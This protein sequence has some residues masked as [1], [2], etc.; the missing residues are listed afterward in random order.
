MERQLSAILAADVVGYSRLMEADAQGTLAK[1]QRLRAERF[2]PAVAGHRGKVVKSMGDGWIVSFNSASD[3]VT[4]A[5]RLQDQM[6]LEPDI[7]IRIGV[8]VGDISVVDEDVFGEGVNIAAR[9]EALTEPGGVSVSDAVHALL[10]GTLRP[11]FDEAGEHSLKN[12]DRPVRVWTRGGLTGAAALKDRTGMEGFPKVSIRPVVTSSADPEMRELA[13]ALTHD[14]ATYLGA[15]R[16]LRTRVAAG[17]DAA[18]YVLT[19]NL[20]SSG[21]RMRFE[22]R[23][24]SPD[25]VPIWSDKFDGAREDAFDWQDQTGA[26]TAN[27]VLAKVLD[28]AIGAVDA[29]PE[30]ERSWED[31]I[32]QSQRAYSG[33]G[34]SLGLGLALG[35]A[36]IAKAPQS[37]FPYETCLAVWAAASSIGFT[38]VAERYADQTGHWLEKARELAGNATTAPAYLAFFEYVSKGDAQ[39]A[40]AGVN[41]FLRDLPFDPEALVFAGF[42]LSY[43]G[44]PELSLQCL[45]RFHQFASHHPFAPPA[46][47]GSGASKAMLERYDEALAD[48]DASIQLSPGY[49][50]PYRWKASVLALMGRM[51][52]ARAALAAHQELMPGLTLSQLRAT[53]MRA[54]TPGN[55]RLYEG[56]R[57]AGMPD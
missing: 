5:M 29:K 43:I 15:T 26:R 41:A 56:L 40:L 8:H 44:E 45:G 9:L 35:T 24:A 50:T 22:A 6:V 32:I 3:A 28:H 46:F 39:K 1:L 14:M 10:D 16:W 31:L 7:Q 12:I 42:L 23:L 25:G 51:Q 2:A 48:F 21:A 17:G 37:S 36:A 11:A 55:E 19:A 38:E 47:A 13:N 49:P 18:G 54:E 30:E 53:N 52:E 57:L 20:R 33:D 4:F 34:K 27:R